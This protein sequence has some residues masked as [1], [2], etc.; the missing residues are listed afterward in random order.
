MRS[1]GSRRPHHDSR[2]VRLAE[3]ARLLPNSAWTSSHKQ[4]TSPRS[5]SQPV[6]DVGDYVNQQ[7]ERDR[8]IETLNRNMLLLLV[9]LRRRGRGMDDDEDNALESLLCVDHDHC[10]SR[11]DRQLRHDK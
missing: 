11:A 2:T 4:I 9:L 3:L 7:L 5:V 6:F 8:L 10:S 1:I